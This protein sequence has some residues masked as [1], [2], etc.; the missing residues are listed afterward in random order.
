MIQRR[1]LPKVWNLPFYKLHVTVNLFTCLLYKTNRFYVAVHLFSNRK[2]KTS[3]L[4]KEHRWHTRLTA[5]RRLFLFLPHFDV[6]CDLLLNWH[7]ATWNLFVK[8]KRWKEKFI[9][10]RWKIDIIYSLWTSGH[11]AG[12]LNPLFFFTPL[13]FFSH[14]SP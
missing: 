2:Q 1:K 12:H 14:L 3:K 10:V 7:T 11:N 4:W 13:V 9:L 8:Y 6:I 5:R